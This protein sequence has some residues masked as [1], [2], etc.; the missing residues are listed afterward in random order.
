MPYKNQFWLPN[1]PSSEQF[2]KEP[3]F[4]SVKNIWTI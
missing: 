3:F 1:E 2:L 4:L